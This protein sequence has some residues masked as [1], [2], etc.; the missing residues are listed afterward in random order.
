MVPARAEAYADVPDKILGTE[1]SQDAGT[2]RDEQGIRN[3]LV[4]Q[5]RAAS[6]EVHVSSPYVVPTRRSLDTI[7]MLQRRGVR[8]T[9]LTN[10]LA[11]TDEPII[12]SAYRRYRDHML[13][14]GVELHEIRPLAMPRS[15]RDG[16]PG[17]AVARLHA[18]TVVID[19]EIFYIGS[20]NF[21]PRSATHNT[22]LG[23]I[24]FSPEIARQALTLLDGLKR[25]R[26]HELRLGADGQE[27]HWIA[28]GQDGG[29]FVDREADPG[30][31]RRMLLEVFGP[32][33]PDDLL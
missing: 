23:I 29:E 32:F 4:Q 12:H 11:A 10:S 28:R 27:I 9:V 3:R 5:I 7:E 25:E 17:V 8:M 20:F 24:V 14:Q 2:P 33:V 6:M 18:K 30:W 1:T 15:I 31:W 26:S 13:R 16:R 21:D 22:E 19:R